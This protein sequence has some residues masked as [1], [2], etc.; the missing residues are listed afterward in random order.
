ML[1]PGI[2]TLIISFTTFDQ[3]GT[4]HFVKHYSP[5]TSCSDKAKTKEASRLNAR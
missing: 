5:E 2:H 1:R 3:K 4:L